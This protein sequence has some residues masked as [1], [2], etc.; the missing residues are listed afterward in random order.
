MLAAPRLRALVEIANVSNQNPLI[1]RPGRVS[2]KIVV[3]NDV[4]RIPAAVRRLR[5][6]RFAATGATTVAS[7][8]D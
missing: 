2:A 3:G 1:R 4:W 7:K 5:A 6:G 8:T